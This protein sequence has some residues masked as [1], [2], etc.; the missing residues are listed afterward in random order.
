MV[1]AQKTKDEARADAKMNWQHFKENSWRNKMKPFF[2]SRG[3]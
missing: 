2:V 1:E 3:T